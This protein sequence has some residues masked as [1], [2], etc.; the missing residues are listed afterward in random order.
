MLA[1]VEER[2]KR[3]GLADRIRLHCCEP[4]AIGL[5]RTVDFALAFWMA[6][7]VPDL[8]AF[9][10]EVLSLLAPE[11]RFLLIEPKIHV[12]SKAFEETIAK[13][14]DKG[15]ALLGRPKVRFSR[16]VLLGKK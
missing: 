3:A 15:F 1:M 6:H 10:G 13:A 9:L 5:D 11:G 12:G 14:L 7:E 4:H 8:D 2:A 16:G